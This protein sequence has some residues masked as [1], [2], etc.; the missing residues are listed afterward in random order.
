[1]TPADPP[2]GEGSPQLFAS[3]YAELHRLAERQLGRAGAGLTLSTTT[4]LH[5]AYLDIAA[6]PGVHFPDRA[7]FL[8]YAARAMRGIVI[9]YA[10]HRGAR[11]RGGGAFEITLTADLRP[12]A[13]SG[14]DAGDAAELE[15]L[16]DALDELAGLD[17]ALAELVDLHFFCG[18][19]LGEIAGMREVSERTVQRDWRKARLLLHHALLGDTAAGDAGR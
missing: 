18:Y 2:S 3:L 7:R 5:E 19:S 1:M 12:S 14:G 11:K 6:R 17:P 15:R 8:A 13:G 4:L 9:D 10:R 16:S